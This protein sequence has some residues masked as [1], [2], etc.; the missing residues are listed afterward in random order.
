[1]LSNLM[2]IS[3]TKKKIT[4]LIL[5]ENALPLFINQKKLFKDSIALLETK[6]EIKSFMLSEDHL[7]QVYFQMS[8]MF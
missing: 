5:K 6:I 7:V 3:R 1:M 2:N 4:N 8:F